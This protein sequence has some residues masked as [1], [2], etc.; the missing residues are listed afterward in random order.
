MRVNGQLRGKH[1]FLGH[2]LTRSFL[3]IETALEATRGII[4]PQSMESCY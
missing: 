1:S 4:D 3:V 2:V